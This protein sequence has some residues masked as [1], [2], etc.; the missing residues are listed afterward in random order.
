M[1]STLGAALFY[2]QEKGWPVV[3]VWPADFVSGEPVCRCGN[4]GCR[5][6]GKHPVNKVQGRP[7]APRGVLDATTNEQVLTHWWSL[8][9]DA[10]I[11]V[12]GDAF[13]ALDVDEEDGLFQ[14][15]SQYGQLPDT[16]E[17]LSGSGGRHILFKQPEGKILGNEEGDLPHGINVRGNRGYIIVAPSI[18]K[19]G[20]RY[21]WELS[22]HPREVELADAPEWLIELIGDPTEAAPIEEVV[23]AENA[24]DLDK[25][26]IHTSMKSLIQTPPVEGEDRSSTDQKVIVALYSA[27]CE[28]GEIKAIF[29]NYPIGTQG[30]YAERGDEYLD[31]SIAS[32]VAYVGPV[33]KKPTKPSLIV[34]GKSVPEHEARLEKHALDTAYLKGWNAALSSNASIA[35][36]LWPDRLS[37]SSASISHYGLG[38]RTDYPVDEGEYA[39]LVVPYTNEGKVGN[40]GYELYSQPKGTPNTVWESEEGTHV[41]DTDVDGSSLTGRVLVTED[42]D[43]AMHTYLN[44]GHMFKWLAVLG[45]PRVPGCMTEESKRACLQALAS[46]LAG[47]EQVLLAWPA[48]RRK[49]GLLLADMLEEG[50]D[51]VF[52]LTLPGPMRQMYKQFGMESKH[53][54]RYIQQAA[55]IV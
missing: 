29:A 33:S 3:P 7:V 43:T 25:L 8:I 34:P 48:G 9:P 35:D 27:G 39:A 13:F 17:S 6:I 49:D 54:N 20:Q 46:L 26:D 11:G 24:P 15:V 28:P 52:W 36:E 37:I 38:M 45:L 16:V 32:A 40:I 10:N 31:R 19:S 55:P 14:L 2:A 47:S 12:R 30:K 53:L 4:P 51:R 5:S 21:E 1:A 44:F 18:H 23:C 22:S 50:E 42:W 41:F